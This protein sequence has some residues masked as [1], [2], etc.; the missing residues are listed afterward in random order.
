MRLT[1]L[2]EALAELEETSSRV[3]MVHI[4]AEL[5]GEA[6]PDERAPIVYLLQAQLRPPYE[7]VVIGLGEKFIA[8]AIA[9]AF[10]VSLTTVEGRFRK[11][12]DL[13]LV[14]ASVA[15]SK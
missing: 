8:R 10:D 7:G 15:P 3:R 14:A 11:S 12:G 9:E 1:V 4:V 5:L 6:D 2:A 13:G